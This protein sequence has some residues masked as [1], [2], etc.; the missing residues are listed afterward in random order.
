[1]PSTLLTFVGYR[2]PFYT[3][4]HEDGRQKGGVLGILEHRKFDRIVLFGRTHRRENLERTRAALRE[5]HPQLEVEV[6]ELALAD[7]TYHP[8]VLGRLRP[9]LSRLKRLRPDDDFAVSLL[10][11]TPEIHACW[12][13]L[14]VSGEFRARLLNYRRSVHNGLA[15]PRQLRELDLTEPLAAIAPET[16]SMLT[17]RGDRGSDP[18]ATPSTPAV[19]RHYFIKRCIDQAVQLSRHSAPLLILGEPGT[20]K[21]Q[22]A[23]LVHQLGPRRHGPLLI[24]N[25]AT[26]PAPLFDAAL[27]GER[28]DPAGGKICQADGGTLLLLKV[29]FVPAPVL[30]RLFQFV[31]AGGF[32]AD[33]NATTVKASVRLMATSDRDLEEEVRQGR[34]P[35]EIWRRLQGSM[36]RLPPL[37]E[38]PGDIGLLARDELE[39]LNRALP[40]P[41]RFA[42]AAVAKLE[43]HSWPGNISEL[44]RVV[45]RGVAK[46]EQPVIQPDD[47]EVDLSVNHT[48][49]PSHALPRIQEGFSLE[50]YLRMIKHELVQGVLRKTGGNQSHAARL[51]GVT[52]QAISKLLKGGPA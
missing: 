15:G 17:A 10:S 38:R 31:D 26:L 48:N 3:E 36:V 52:P 22:M 30:A 39:R 18:A 32:Q 11:G 47:L 42:S 37:R 14:V 25:C 20:Q 1:M 23:A 12:V 51:L 45:E 19:P 46:A 5:F 34:F 8:D 21:Q 35:P 4:P 24:L 50:E 2:D 33:G 6:H 49:A 13:L 40:Q 9:V 16:L 27:F 29:Q 43:S 44:R 7:S 28:T 41:R